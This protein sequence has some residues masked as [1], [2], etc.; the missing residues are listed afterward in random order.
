MKILLTGASGFLGSILLEELRKNHEVIS[1]GR[2]DSNQIIADLA[3]EK[4]EIPEV[5]ILIHSAGKAHSVPK[6]EAEKKEFFAVNFEGTKNLIEGIKNPPKQF[7]FIS[8]VAVYGLEKG[9]LITENHDLDAV[10]PYGKSKIMAEQLVESWAK[11]EGINYLILRLPLV[12]GANPPGNLGAMI[13]AIRK[14]YYFR[15]G[16]AESKKSMVLA[17]DLAQQL[18]KWQG[19]SGIYNLTDGHDPKMKELEAYLSSQFGKSVKTFP[20]G[21]LNFFAKVGDRISAFPLNSYRLEKLKHSLTFSSEKAKHELGWEPRS[22]IGN[23]R[24]SK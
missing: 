17:E 2:G 11:R 13:K 12:V 7:V 15:L 21:P 22:V 4:P 18:L 6:T 16:S 3:K 14:G 23:F 10:S 24:I 19:H 9:E 1:L 20:E 5:D 8:T